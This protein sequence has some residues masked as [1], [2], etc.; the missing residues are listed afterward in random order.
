MSAKH[1]VNHCMR[2]GKFKS[3]GDLSVEI[4]VDRGQFSRIYNGKE[5]VSAI[6]MFHVHLYLGVP[7]IKIFELTMEE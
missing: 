7:I 5:S 4:D 6:F 3:H 1:L 2:I